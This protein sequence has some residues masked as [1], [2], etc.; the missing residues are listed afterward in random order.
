MNPEVQSQYCNGS[1][2]PPEA[3]ASAGGGN[4]N[5]GCGWAVPPGIAD[6]TV[7]NPIFN[8]TPVATVDEGNN[9]INLRWGPLSLTN[10]TVKGADGNYGGGAPLGNYALA[11]SSAAIDHI[12][13]PDIDA[14]GFP[15]T[16]FFGHPRPDPT[17]PT[18]FDVGAV[19]YQGNGAAIQPVLIS[20][21]P[22]SGLRGS[23][24]NVTLTGT[25]LTEVVA[26]NAPGSPNITV[27]NVVVVNDSMVTATLTLAPLT[28]LALGGHPI[29][30]STPNF[31]SNNVTFTVLGPTVTAISPNSGYRGTTVGVTITGTGLTGALYVSLDSGLNSRICSIVAPPTAT[32]V[33]ASCALTSATTLG[34]KN[35]T[36]QTPIGVATGTGLFTVLGPT[37]TSISPASHALGGSPFLV[38]LTGIDL[39]G[40]TGVTVSGTGFTITGVTAV[41]Y[42]TVTATFQ[43]AATAALG[44]RTV[45]V[46][47]PN[48][49]TNTVPFQVTAAP[50]AFSGPTPALTTTTANVTVAGTGIATATPTSANFTAN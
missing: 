48:G 46:T 34:V 42:T 6:A 26:V 18:A 36:V 10:P 37:L 29:N 32:T 4:N 17:N 21:T 24:V 20:I 40:A 43:I 39:T 7:P 27:S 28:L 19:E 45:S 38:T 12:P 35:V 47:T 25:G 44:S 16:D 49:T 5:G 13:V 15:T 3:C 8:L 2:Q 22:N 11:S 50:L 14:V 33:Q 23:S 1:R 30:V 31:T 9:W 41:N